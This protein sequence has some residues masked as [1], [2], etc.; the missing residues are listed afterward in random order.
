M[1]AKVYKR[2]NVI[3]RKCTLIIYT[4]TCAMAYSDK[5][6]SITLITAER[7][8]LELG[9][10]ARVQKIRMEGLPGRGRCL[11]ISSA[12]WI[13]YTNVTDDDDGGRGG[14]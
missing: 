2:R 7:V 9:T 1:L 8:P 3:V 4:L 12:L 5:D 6:V 13:Q 11:T 10:G 14:R